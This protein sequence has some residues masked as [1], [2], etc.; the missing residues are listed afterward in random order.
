M[1]AF[2]NSGGIV[3]TIKDGILKRD[4]LRSMYPCAVGVKYPEEGQWMAV[5]IN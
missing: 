2:P 5:P 4:D 3:M 1:S